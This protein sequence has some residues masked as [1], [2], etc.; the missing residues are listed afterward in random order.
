MRPRAPTTDDLLADARLAERAAVVRYLRAAADDLRAA[1][2]SGHTTARWS[3]E[4]VRR[5][6]LTVADE[7]D[8][9]HHLAAR[10]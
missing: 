2:V 5:E 1:T 8:E 4:A 10:P 7:I 3:A 9:G 6:L